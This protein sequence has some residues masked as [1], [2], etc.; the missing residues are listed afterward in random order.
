MEME[1]V[2]SVSRI[3]LCQI[4]LLIE[5]FIVLGYIGLFKKKLSDQQ[6]QENRFKKFTVRRLMA[7]VFDILSLVIM[8]FFRLTEPILIP[9]WFYYFLFFLFLAL[10][11]MMY[12]TQIL[13]AK[14]I[15]NDECQYNVAINMRQGQA[16]LVKGLFIGMLM[17]IIMGNYIQLFSSSIPIGTALLSI[18]SYLCFIIIKKQIRTLH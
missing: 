13:I 7:F 8:V 14:Q 11:I 18:S 9:F 15:K 5:I 3:L 17:Y 2:A 12:I 10:I 1:M 6:E 4:I 16:D